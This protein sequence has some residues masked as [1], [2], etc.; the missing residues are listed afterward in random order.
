[1]RMAANLKP[2]LDIDPSLERIIQ[3]GVSDVIHL[4]AQVGPPFAGVPERSVTCNGNP[5]QWPGYGRCF[6]QEEIQLI[7]SWGI[8][9]RQPATILELLQTREL[10]KFISR[11]EWR[12]SKL[13]VIIR[14]PPAEHDRVFFHYSP[15]ASI[16]SV[17]ERGLEPGHGFLT[18]NGKSYVGVY[19]VATSGQ[20]L[21]YRQYTALRCSDSTRSVLTSLCYKLAVREENVR[22]IA[23][24]NQR[25]GTYPVVVELCFE[26]LLPQELTT[27]TKGHL[28][29]GEHEASVER[30][31]MPSFSEVADVWEAKKEKTPAGGKLLR[32]LLIRGSAAVG[33]HTGEKRKLAKI[34]GLVPERVILPRAPLKRR[35]AKTPSAKLETVPAQR[36]LGVVALLHQ[37]GTMMFRYTIGAQGQTVEEA[38]RFLGL[39]PM[40]LRTFS[41][42]YNLWRPDNA[43]PI[44]AALGRSKPRLIIYDAVIRMSL[45]AALGL[46]VLKFVGPPKE[47]SSETLFTEWFVAQRVFRWLTIEFERVATTTMGLRNLHMGYD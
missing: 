46:R 33:R 32:P 34:K 15:L 19:C 3:D 16:G 22:R 14:H 45:P 6:L 41:P 26:M 11:V 42:N 27:S 44:S 35:R 12:G 4:G 25:V 47:D 10:T 39:F 37:K 7:Q 38:R 29:V 30:F 21:F 20:A 40:D 17:L 18:R 5:K 31:L 28:W 1:M 23:G 8:S 2:R 24:T 43:W 36:R 13:H 9:C